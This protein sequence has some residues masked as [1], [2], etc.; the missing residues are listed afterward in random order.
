MPLTLP[1]IDDRTYQ[2]LLDEALARVPSHNPEWTG[3]NPSDPGVTI[4]EVFAFL[5]ETLLYRSNQIPERNRR[6]FLQLL[7]VPLRPASAARGVAQVTNDRG[8]RQAVTLPAD[9]ALRA[10]E[11][12]FRTTRGLDVLPVEARAYYKRLLA[13]VPDDV[14]GYYDRLY[15][16]E[17]APGSGAR[18]RAYETVPFAHRG[19]DR[20]DLASAHGTSLW[21]ALLARESDA[22]PLASVRDSLKGRTLSF[23]LVPVVPDEGVTLRPAEG[24]DGGRARWEFRLPRV[25]LQGDGERAIA[26]RPRGVAEYQLLDATPVGDVWREPGVVDVQLPADANRLRFWEDL[27]PLESGVGDLPPDLADPALRARLI[28]W[29]KVTPVGA[30]QPRL[31]WMGANAVPVVQRERVDDEPLPDGTG[32]PDQEAAL[33]HGSV[34]ADT[35]RLTVDGEPWRAVDDLF[36]AGAEIAVA[37]PRRPPGA[38]PKRWDPKDADAY[39]LDAE[40]GRVRFG[41]G[42]RGRRPPPGAALRASYAWSAGR[43]GNVGA[44]A[45]D[46]GVGLPPGLRVSNPVGAWGGAD[47]EAVADGERRIAKH[48]RHRDRLVTEEDF[49]EIARATPGADLARVDVL[50]AYHPDLGASEPGDAPGAVTLLVVPRY[51]PAHPDAPEADAATLDAVACWLAPRRLVTAEVVLRKAS[52]RDVWASVGVEVARGAS[53]PTVRE[54]VAR[55]VRQFLAP[56]PPPEG[57]ARVT[58]VPPGLERGYPLARTLRR[59]ELVAEVGRV[60]GVAL[61]RGLALGNAAGVE[62]EQVEFHGLELPRLAGLSVALGDPPSI[63]AL[64]GEVASGAASGAVGGVDGG[65]GVDGGVGAPGG[66]PGAGGAGAG[67]AGAGGGGGVRIVPVPSAPEEC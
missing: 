67:G 24:G 46:K 37:D 54:A 32:E 9:V 10:G 43:A 45:I 55:A 5:T 39:A 62:V 7:E 34:L 51:D 26:A 65:A 12:P 64:R 17:R 19:L 53:A 2:Q 60:P 13:D 48:L 29:V 3:F 63:A 40:A 57:E 27:E 31:A 25:E 20:V 1:R 23:G 35:L 41:D 28:T 56:L 18:V 42:L 21:V 14:Q 4:L 61:V 36:E 49:E 15:A 16:A 38:E 59:L 33:A 50:P 66:L 8:P 44:G 11:V 30:T 58:P 47:A 22:G 6:K 52:Y